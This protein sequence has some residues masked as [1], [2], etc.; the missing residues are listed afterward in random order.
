M[1]MFKRLS[2]IVVVTTGGDGVATGSGLA[3]IPDGITRLIGIAVDYGAT[4]PGTTDVTIKCTLPMLK[5]LLTLT[6]NA[7]DLA[8]SQITEVELDGT[9]SGR[10]SPATQYPLVMGLLTVD[11]AQ[12]NALAVAVT[13]TAVVELG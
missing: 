10:A 3:K 2:P 1:S 8:L 5:T 13:V 12:C 9:G 6:D 11:V 7:T 4:A